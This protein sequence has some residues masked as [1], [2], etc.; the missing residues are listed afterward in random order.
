MGNSVLKAAESLKY[1]EKKATVILVSDGI[2]TCDVDLCELG[3]KLESTGVDFTAHVIGFD[4]TK[5][6]TK[7]LKCL[8][9][10]T[11]GEFILAKDA[12]S[13]TEAL[14]KAIESSSC[15]KEKLGEATITAPKE[16]SAGSSFEIKYTGPKNSDDF[17]ALV[18]K[19]STNS[20]DHISYLYPQKDENE[21]I[22]PVETGEYDIVYWAGR[23]K[24][25]A[26]ETITVTN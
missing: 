26:R 25:L 20:N 14:G 6:Q 1:T 23:D 8:A 15:S 3:K 10:E 13:L 5:E 9:K 22:A 19:G 7:G 4:M 18:P 16:V 2:E 12:G 24:E 11:G 21:L 17:I